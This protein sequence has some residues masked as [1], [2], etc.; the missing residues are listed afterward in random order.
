MPKKPKHIEEK[1]DE[2]IRKDLT[3]GEIK[4]EVDVSES[5]IS[6]R[7]KYLKKE[8]AKQ[9]ESKP[10]DIPFELSKKSQKLLY[11]LMGML[12][13]DSMDDLVQVVS[14]DY[15]SLMFEKYKYDIDN[16]LTVAELFN[17]FKAN[18]ELVENIGDTEK[19]IQLLTKLGMEDVIIYY[20][21]FVDDYFRGS[22]FD[23]MSHY[24]Q[25]YWKE[26]KDMSIITFHENIFLNQE[27][28]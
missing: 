23:F 25:L 26:V 4:N 11:N 19:Q 21:M 20:R 27:G 12:G 5:Y 16:E 13:C 1:V 15:K 24:S 8:A 7:R 3:F 18:H 14:G 6:G 22:L 17:R 2:L 28:G 9:E 10:T